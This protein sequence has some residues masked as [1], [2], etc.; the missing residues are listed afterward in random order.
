MKRQLSIISCSNLPKKERMA[1]YGKLLH[2]RRKQFLTRKYRKTMTRT[3]AVTYSSQ[4]IV[5]L[6]LSKSTRFFRLKAT[7]L[8]EPWLTPLLQPWTSK[9]AL[10][11][12]TLVSVKTDLDDFLGPKTTLSTWISN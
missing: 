9:L 12:W 11:M 2:P 1:I 4:I 3:K 10:T 7:Y 5:Q 8:D 6:S